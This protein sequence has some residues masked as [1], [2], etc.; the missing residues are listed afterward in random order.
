MKITQRNFFFI[1]SLLLPINAIAQQPTIKQLEMD[2]GLSNNYVL[3]I[4]EDKYGFLWF[5][6]E[7]GLNVFDGLTFRTYYKKEGSGLSN[8]TNGLTG[9]ELNCVMDDPQQPILWIGTQREGL[10]AFDYQKGTFS[11]YRHDNKNPKSLATNDITSISKAHDG[12]LWLT[13]YWKGLEYF[14]KRT[15]EFIHYNTSNVKGLTDNQMWTSLDLGNGRVM[16]GHG[17]KGVSIIDTRTRKAINF[18]HTDGD[19]SSLAG[20]DVHCIYRDTKGNIWIG[21]NRGLDLFD[22]K[23]LKISHFTDGGRLQRRIFDI[24]ETQGRQLWI[25]TELGGIAIIDLNTVNPNNLKTQSSKPQNLAIR[26]INTGSVRCIHEDK[27]GNKWIGTYGEGV[28]FISHFQPLFGRIVYSPTNN[29][30][31]LTDK[32]VMTL[33]LDGSYLWA[34]TDLGGMDIFNAYRQR[35]KAIPFGSSVQASLSDSHGRIWLG[36]FNG[37]AYISEG[38]KT[39]R[40]A[41]MPEYEDVRSFYESRNGQIYISTSRGLYIADGT[42][43]KIVSH[44]DFENNFVRSVTE[45]RHGR[46]Y[47]ATFGG[48]LYVSGKGFMT[49]EKGFPS[50]TVNQVLTDSRGTVWAA[51]GEGLVKFS[52]TADNH[53]QV[54]NHR[55]GLD[56][57]HIKAITEDHQH[58]IWVSTNKGISCLRQGSNSFINYNYKDNVPQGNFYAGSVAKAADGTIYFGSNN[59]LCYFQPERVLK[60]RESARTEI[61]SLTIISNTDQEDSVIYLIKDKDIHLDYSQNTVAVTFCI[62]DYAIADNMEYAY[63]L[64]GLSTDWTFANGNTITFRELQH[65][66]YKLQVKSRFRNQQWSGNVAELSFVIEPPFWL[67]WWAK[68]LYLLIVV[69]VMWALLRNYKHRVRLEFL[70]KTEKTAHEQE[71]RLNDE[72]LRFFTNITHELRTPLTLILGPL[73]DM[74]R[75]KSLSDELRR[76]ISI[77]RDNGNKLYDLISNI[78]EFRKTETSVRRLCVGR[79]NVVA[80]VRE[81]CQKFQE[82]NRNKDLNIR[83]ESSDEIINIYFDKDVIDTIVSNFVSNALKYTP[84]GEIVVRTSQQEYGGTKYFELSVSDTGYGIQREALPKIFDRYYQVGGEH[85]QSGTGIGLALVKSLAELHKGTVG[86]ESELGRGSRFWFRLRQDNTYSDSPHTEVSEKPKASNLDTEPKQA[87]TTTEQEERE[88]Q[89]MLIVEDNTDICQYIADSFT[90]EFDIIMAENGSDGL[91]KALQSLP[92]IIISDVM[93]PEMDGNEMCHR[94]KTDLRTSHIPI[95]LLTAKDS[96]TAREEGYESGADSYIT[97]PF[98]SS[99]LASRVHNILHQRQIL[100]DTYKQKSNNAPIQSRQEQLRQALSELDRKFLSKV[101]EQ[102]EAN[103]ESERFNLDALSHQLNMSVSTL[104]RKITAVTGMSANEY[105]RKYRMRKAAA[106]LIEGRYTIAEVGYKVGISTAAYFRRLFKEEY[107]M[108]PSEYIKK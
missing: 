22:I 42:T 73:D 97:K 85:Q 41:R 90:D 83:F 4:A 74:T 28:G 89:I 86:A 5:A 94:L 17:N 2:A 27:Y 10:N 16:V 75:D 98:V 103:I 51:T 1:L 52:S 58:N 43:T 6:T 72:R 79:G 63:K 26:Y 49:R 54:Y 69:G 7:E 77:M 40:L 38:G 36:L 71:N 15:K 21:T 64:N 101:D 108:T 91:D 35:T 8:T 23:T 59:G 14:D 80:I 18:S 3:S 39:K 33:S 20:G 107:G 93:M 25:S 99:L 105:I 19:A 61:T 50:N 84:R 76:R 29:E 95:I 102:I 37:G 44:R 57:I 13:T 24:K 56:N 12:N 65:G 68:T 48:G 9:N 32:S 67:T 70:L 106:L 104:Y 81:A 96:M 34:G 100:A 55:Q 66:N 88:R 78:L 45:D 82:L 60:K 47:V 11:Y 87:P 46:L 53:Y 62:D 30:T 92:D 31:G